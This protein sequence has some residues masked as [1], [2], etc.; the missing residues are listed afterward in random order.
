MSPAVF[1]A[2]LCQC[3]CLLLV[4]GFMHAGS[5][6][7]LVS[8]DRHYT[9]TMKSL[10]DKLSHGGHEVVVMVPEVS[11]EQ[12]RPLNSPRK[13]HLASHTWWIRVLLTSVEKSGM[14]MFFLTVTS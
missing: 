2:S 12:G 6:L 8:V 4:S 3:V 13:T 10:L 7:L 1:P 5:R 11:W 9:F 14:E